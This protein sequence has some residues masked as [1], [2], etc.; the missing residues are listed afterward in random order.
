MGRLC[1]LLACGLMCAA[2]GCSEKE[3]SSP[4][5]PF[6]LPP[7][8]EPYTVPEGTFDVDAV[9]SNINI[10]GQHFDLPQPIA[11]LGENW[12]FRYYDRK[13]YGLKEGSGLATLY[14]GGT[15]MGTV[16][17]ENCYSGKEK[18]SVM[19]SISIKTSDSDIYGITPLVSTVDDVERL[20][21]KP[22][23]VDTN[24]KPY[25]NIYHYGINL[26]EDEKGILRGHNI[27]VSFDESGVVDL[28]SITYSHI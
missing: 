28:V 26:G 1:L 5:I 20:I 18:N 19:Y 23:S 11:D 8:V 22:D 21:G 2:V 7:I 6:E 15:A 16:S 3:S 17:L 12:E 25:V 13:D 9:R 14:Y 27:A 24:P 4:E 10:K